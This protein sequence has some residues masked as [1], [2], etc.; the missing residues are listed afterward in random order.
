[1]TMP[2]V[3]LP[4]L[5]SL[6]VSRKNVAVT[7]SMVDEAI[8]S[9]R[10]NASE[11]EPVTDRPS[12]EGDLL[13]VMYDLSLFEEKN[14]EAPQE[15]DRQKSVVE[16]S[17]EALPEELFS[18]LLDRVAGDRVEV[19]VRVSPKDDGDQRTLRYKIE[20]LSVARKI[21]PELSGPFFEKVV[22]E[23]DLDEEGFRLKIR[24]K[25]QE[26]LL[27]ESLQRAEREALDLL[28]KRSQVDVP[29]SLVQRHKTRILK[30][31]HENVR[32][33]TGKTFE[34]YVAQ[35]GLEREKLE[36]EAVEG[37][38]EEVRRSLV[39]DALAEAE[40]IQVEEEDLDGEFGEMARSFNI[41]RDK[42]KEF[43]LKNPD[44][45]ADLQHR[46]RMKKAVKRL[47]EKVA[48]SEETLESPFDGTGEAEI[49]KEGS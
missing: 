47:M 24:E 45:L 30:D 41:D 10:D 3:A 44:D 8:S 17:R 19:D 7:P 16:L 43:F 15:S 4:E 21:L 27:A 42:I 48:V 26:N 1:E 31:L 29:D 33:K 38:E 2:E 34:E 36:A 22:G 37:A 35:E 25:L 11:R 5:E 6:E 20:V 9:L 39:M 13:E 14:G 46:V 32:R 40:A 18:A 12:G 28:V 49:E 23:S